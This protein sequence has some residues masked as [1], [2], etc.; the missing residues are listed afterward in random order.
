L[1]SQPNSHRR[2]RENPVSYP[3]VEE[4]R[5]VTFVLKYSLGETPNND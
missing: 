5:A 1:V 2:K 4:K 3:P